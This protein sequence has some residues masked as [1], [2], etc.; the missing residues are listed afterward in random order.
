MN[1]V[2]K[3]YYLVTYHYFPA[4]GTAI[5]PYRSKMYEFDADKSPME[6]FEFIDSDLNKNAKNEDPCYF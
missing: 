3:K 6:C 4:R 5:N 1:T 2:G